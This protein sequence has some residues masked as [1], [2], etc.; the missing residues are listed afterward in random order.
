MTDRHQGGHSAAFTDGLK[1]LM[2]GGL[3]PDTRSFDIAGMPLAITL[4]R[5]TWEL[6]AEAARI[7]GMGLEDLVGLVTG[8]C[9]APPS[10]DPAPLDQ[11]P[12]DLA[13]SG[14]DPAGDGDQPLPSLLQSIASALEL[15][16]LA[17]FRAAA[18]GEIGVGTGEEVTSGAPGAEA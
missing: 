12:L 7:E 15:F 8:R 16:A 18:P 2:E 11:V 1:A 14:P 10:P 17:Y 6:L 5:R 13:P 9:L 3:S 4:E